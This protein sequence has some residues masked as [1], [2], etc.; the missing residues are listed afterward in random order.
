MD[1]ERYS[2]E[3]RSDIGRFYDI[4]KDA[5]DIQAYYA[6]CLMSKRLRFLMIILIC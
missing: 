4:R 1:D 2:E 6:G 5:I 3:T